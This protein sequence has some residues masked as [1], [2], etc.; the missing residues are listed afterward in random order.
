MSLPVDPSL[1]PIVSRQA[2]L[3]SAL[4]SLRYPASTENSP[5]WLLQQAN[6]CSCQEQPRAPQ[7]AFAVFW[8]QLQVLPSVQPPEIARIDSDRALVSIAL[9]LQMLGFPA[10]AQGENYQHG[11]FAS[12]LVDP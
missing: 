7:A 10:V 5:G 3:Y 11:G 12:V 6:A 9:D 4:Q 1:R 8:V 2:Q